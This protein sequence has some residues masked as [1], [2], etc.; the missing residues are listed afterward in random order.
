MNTYV[1]HLK[2][3][4]II[5]LNI[6]SIHKVHRGQNY[7]ENGDEKRKGTMHEQDKYRVT[8]W[9]YMYYIGEIW[10]FSVLY[11]HLGTICTI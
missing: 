10:Y 5:L 11:D 2:T 3:R 7:K 1:N 6:I 8:R 9:Y 4:K